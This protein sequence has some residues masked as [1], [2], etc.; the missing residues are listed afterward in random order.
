MG[1][2]TLDVSR[3]HLDFVRVFSVKKLLHSR[4]LCLLLGNTDLMLDS[5]MDEGAKL[6]TRVEGKQMKHQSDLKD[7]PYRWFAGWM[8]H[9]RREGVPSQQRLSWC[10]SDDRE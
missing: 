3:A 6:I 4:L 8:V 10:P 9:R 2:Q 7:R 1:D 5:L